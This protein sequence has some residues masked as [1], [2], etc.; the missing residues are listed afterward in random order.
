MDHYASRTATDRRESEIRKMK[1]FALF[2][3]I[4]KE[5]IHRDLNCVWME[6]Y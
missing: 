2:V 5:T 1:R 6:G 3:L 4:I